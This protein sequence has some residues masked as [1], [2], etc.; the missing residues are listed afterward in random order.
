VDTAEEMH[1]QSLRLEADAGA[2]PY[3]VNA[4]ESVAGMASLAES[5]EEAGRL[6]AAADLARHLN[7]FH[8]YESEV[9]DHADDL[10][11]VKVALGSRF[12]E[13]WSEGASMSL[14]EAVAY[15]TRGRG[16]RKRPSSGWKSLTPTE[17]DVVRL[18]VEGLTNAQIG[19][20]LFMAPGTVKNHL[21][22]VFA[23]TGVTTRTG[24][25]AEVARRRP[26]D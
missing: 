23:K 7:G 11:R 16:G 25:A 4:L 1:Y 12:D 17:M 20:Q 21:S 14:D 5:W 9:P 8:R 10:R 3:V 13:I 19:A 6:L 2:K 15:A 26:D 18:A 24:L 22:H